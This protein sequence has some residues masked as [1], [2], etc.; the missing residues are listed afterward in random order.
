MIPA[1]VKDNAKQQGINN[2]MVGS[3]KFLEE[4]PEK[5]EIQCKKGMYFSFDFGWYSTHLDI[6]H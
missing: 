1:D 4:V 2:L 5:L 6:V 3:C